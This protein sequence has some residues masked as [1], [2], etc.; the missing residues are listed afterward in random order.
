MDKE[1]FVSLHNLFPGYLNELKKPGCTRQ[2][3]W[4]RYK[5]EHVDYYG[6]SQFCQLFSDWLDIKKV[7][8]KLIH[9]AGD[10]LY[11][12]YAGKKLQ[13]VDKDTGEIKDVEGLENKEIGFN[14][15]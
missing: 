4:N 12:D 14:A 9:I 15:K 13:I 3:L 10:K 1:R 5:Q 8:G 2:H 6:Y 11:I 7:S